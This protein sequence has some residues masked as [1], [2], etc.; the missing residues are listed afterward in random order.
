MTKRY[1]LKCDVCGCVSLLKFQVGS[2][3]VTPIRFQCGE[4]EILIE[5]TISVDHK[6]LSI[7]AQFN[8]ASCVQGE[9]P[10]FCL[11]GSRELLVSKSFEVTK[12]E[13]TLQPPPFFK[14]LW[15]MSDSE[16]A[17]DIANF[18]SFSSKYH[19]MG[20]IINNEWSYFK[21][22]NELLFN[23]KYHYLKKELVEILPEG[24]PT[25]RDELEYIKIVGRLTSGFYLPIR[26]EKKFNE[27]TENMK[28]AFLEIKKRNESE[29]KR[30]VL[31][32]VGRNLERYNKRILLIMDNFNKSFEHFIP[33]FGMDFHKS[34]GFLNDS[35]GLSSTSVEDIKQLYV[36]IFELILE[37]Y[38][39]PVGLNNI[40]HRG[41]Y[42][43]MLNIKNHNTLN[44]FNRDCTKANR[45]AYLNNSEL[46]S[47][48]KSDYLDSKFRNAVAHGTYEEEVSSQFISFKSKTNGD[49]LL[50]ICREIFD[51]FSTL[52][53]FYD[54]IIF[55]RQLNY[56][57][58]GKI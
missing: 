10:T 31:S 7:K 2:H 32:F 20:E 15:A 53:D 55:M 54:L 5:G 58:T 14:N 18:N 52:L 13:D 8:N 22:V 38:T 56:H 41:S 37:M 6:T 1:N 42:D 19:E 49:Y 33:V 27:N 25:P 29:L 40:A 45:I 17:L 39:I 43:H 57:Y 12:Y 50:D 30:L 23:K 24:V 28:L 51:S 26:S 3:G 9:M 21:R 44:Q 11:E 4:C 16:G 47:F 34:S 36:D 35:I 46:F 48:I